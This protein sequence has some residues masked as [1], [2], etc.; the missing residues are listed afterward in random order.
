MNKTMK[1]FIGILLVCV[2]GA[3]A[4]VNSP[5][6]EQYK[7]EREKYR[8]WNELIDKNPKPWN[9]SEEE[10]IAKNKEGYCWR[11]KTYYSEKELKDKAMVSLTGKML[12][13]NELYKKGEVIHPL[14]E[15]VIAETASFCKSS[16]T[17]CRVW[18]V[19]RNYSER[20]LI[21]LYEK[22]K[23]RIYQPEFIHEF[24][25]KEVK[26]PEDLATYLQ[27]FG[28][29]GYVLLDQQYY[30]SVYGADCCSIIKN[31]TLADMGES[32]YKG[33]QEG[34]D[35]LSIGWSEL[36]ENHMEYGV[37]N[38]YLHTNN[39]EYNVITIDG[40]TNFEL[41]D[42]EYVYFL[43]NCGDVLYKPYYLH[44]KYLDREYQK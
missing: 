35:Y 34:A 20:D 19:P 21:A 36:P 6:Y 9:V 14:Q 8:Y 7:A 39:F 4:Y 1:I 2:V 18:F 22:N 28:S 16:K 37:G 23:E 3:I 30:P 29:E 32:E 17:D 43:N 33:L 42:Y 25:P 24:N 10:F 15:E 31:F 26:R 41:R 5:V 27:E 38:Y 13:L 40:V 44:S 12:V 11:D